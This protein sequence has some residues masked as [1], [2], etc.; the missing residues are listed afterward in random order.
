SLRCQSNK[1]RTNSGHLYFQGACTAKPKYAQPLDPEWLYGG[2]NHKPIVNR[3]NK[4][5][6]A[7]KL[8]L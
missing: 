8:G 4:V 1:Q 3:R 5:T 2:E 6:L 7:N